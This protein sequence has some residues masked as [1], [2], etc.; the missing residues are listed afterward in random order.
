MD[1][2]TLNFNQ[3]KKIQPLGSFNKQK[4]IGKKECKTNDLGC[5]VFLYVFIFDFRHADFLS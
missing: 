1:G 3:Q 2:W 5:F 4:Y